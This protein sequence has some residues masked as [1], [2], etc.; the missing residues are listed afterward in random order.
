MQEHSQKDIQLLISKTETREK[1]FKLILN[2]YKEKVYW[3]VR[4]ILIVHEDSDD[5]VQNTFIKVW[6]NLDKYRGDS[7]IYTW[8][9]RIAINEAFAFLQKRKKQS[10]KLSDYGQILSEKLE[11]DVYFD[12]TASQLKFQ[13]ALLK[14]PKKQRI[15]FN[16]RYFEEMK[17][18]DMAVILDKS[19]GALKANYHHAVKKIEDYIKNN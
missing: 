8:I 19:E 17:Y 15:V 13:K 3:L 10:L 1:G 16:L 14:L 12:G 7:E 6:Q 4:R 18:Q 11:S 5:V 9:Y 2:L